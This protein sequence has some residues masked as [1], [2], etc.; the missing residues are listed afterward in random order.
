MTN[1]IDRRALM[2]GALGMGAGGLALASGIAPANAAAAAPA[3]NALPTTDAERS[4]MI[5]RMRFRTDAGYIWWWMRGETYAQQGAKLTPLFGLLFGSAMKVTP[6]ADGSVDV[7]QTEVGFRFDLNTG[8]RL[9]TFRNPITNEDIS[10]PYTPVGPTKAH[11]DPNNTLDLPAQVGGAMM[12]L[13]HATDR[14]YRVGEMVAFRTHTAAHVQ[15]EGQADRDVNDLSILFSPAAEALNPKVTNAT[16][17]VQGSDVANY[18]RWLKMPQ[19]SGNQTIRTV[20]QKV[21]SLSDMPQDWLAMVEE[22]EPR[23]AR[24]PEYAFTRAQSPYRN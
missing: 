19:G 13:H 21:T 24:E 14:L 22:E 4:A 17:W 11:Y 20:G 12:Q 23:L 3:L 10:I 8:K 6:N 9:R 18:A 15:T 16:C 1:S 2:G 7:L 5:R